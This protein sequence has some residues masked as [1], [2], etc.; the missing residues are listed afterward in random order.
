[1]AQGIVAH[2]LKVATRSSYKLEHD[3]ADGEVAAQRK[4]NLD[5]LGLRCQHDAILHTVLCSGMAA[6][7]SSMGCG[8]GGFRQH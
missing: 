3:N 2:G 6:L 8:N 1:L 4:D 5:V 7:A